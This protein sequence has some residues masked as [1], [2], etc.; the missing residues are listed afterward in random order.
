MIN[1][2]V[3]VHRKTGKYRGFYHMYTESGAKDRGI[4]YK[5]WKPALKEKDFGVGRYI[6]L[7]SYE[8][9]KED[10]F[11]TP[12]PQM[13]AP[14]ISYNVGKTYV[15]IRIPTKMIPIASAYRRY[16]ESVVTFDAKIPA[17]EKNTVFIHEIFRNGI[18]P[19]H[20]AFMDNIHH[21]LLKAPHRSRDIFIDTYIRIFLYKKVVRS[22]NKAL[23]LSMGL[24]QQLMHY[25]ECSLPDNEKIRDAF[26]LAGKTAGDVVKTAFDLTQAE[27]MSSKDRKDI[28]L[29]LAVMA[30][31]KDSVENRQLNGLNP[32]GTTPIQQNFLTT[33]AQPETQPQL[34]E[35]VDI[36]EEDDDRK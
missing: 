6:L 29:E 35:N 24:Y 21:K 32:W 30:D 31:L 27:S 22:R 4:E 19:E 9:D 2:I 26:D 34:P 11:D 5:Y 1:N 20:V 36:I 12:L 17:K 33:P 18:E 3:V 28:L 8:P 16:W 25:K 7:D 15:Y 13:V 10:M 14:V 23:E